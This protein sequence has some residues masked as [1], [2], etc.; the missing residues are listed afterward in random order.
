M[1]QEKARNHLSEWGLSSGDHD[2]LNKISAIHPTVV[3]IFEGQTHISTSL[4]LLKKSQGIVKVSRVDPLGTM[5][6]CTKFHGKNLLNSC[7]DLLVYNINVLLILVLKEKSRYQQDVSCGKHERLYLIT[8]QTTLGYVIW[9]PWTLLQTFWA[10]PCSRCRDISLNKWRVWPPGDTGGKVKRSP[11]SLGF[12][13]GGL[14][15]FMAVYLILVQIILSGLKLCT[16]QWEY[17]MTSSC[18]NPWKSPISVQW[19]T[20]SGQVSTDAAVVSIGLYFIER[21]AK[22][23]MEKSFC[24]SPSWPQRELDF[25]IA[26]VVRDPEVVRP[27]KRKNYFSAHVSGGSH[28]GRKKL[29]IRR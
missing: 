13:L 28:P 21:W 19:G 16:K 24:S 2:C 3:E 22:V 4:L 14:W 6:V 9:E 27:I 23:M 7:W 11:K 25:P 20:T 17:K 10:N 26:C 1:Q 18:K 8:Y 12:I 15:H 5:N 29:K